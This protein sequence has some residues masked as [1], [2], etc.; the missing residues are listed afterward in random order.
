MEFRFVVW[1][2]KSLSC[3]LLKD[4]DSFKFKC[5]FISSVKIEKFWL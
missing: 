1:S 5:S 4:K 3:V 2:F